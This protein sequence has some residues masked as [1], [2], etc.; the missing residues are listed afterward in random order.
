M[1][2]NL[3]KPWAGPTTREDQPQDLTSDAFV[4]G[5]SHPDGS[6]DTSPMSIMNFDDLLGEHFCCLWMRTG[7]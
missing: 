4:Y 7:R 3:F 2:Q 5:R 1:L 6:E